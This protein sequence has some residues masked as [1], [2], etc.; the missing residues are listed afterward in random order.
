MK[1]KKRLQ[2]SILLSVAVASLCG[3]R[4]GAKAVS[5]ADVCREENHA[6]VALEGYMRL[7]VLMEERVLEQGTRQLLLVEKENGTGGFLPIMAQDSKTKEPNRIAE[8][9]LSY[10]Y[11]DLRIYTEDGSTVSAS[12]RLRVTGEV[13]KDLNSCVLKVQRIETPQ[14]SQTR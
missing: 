12:E 1:K 5:F 2:H 8:L 11:K 6:L 14:S 13:V 9:P 7:P 10:T 3:C 4:E